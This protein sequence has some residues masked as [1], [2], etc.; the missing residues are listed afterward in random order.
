[1]ALIQA[2]FLSEC[3]MRTVTVQAIVPFDKLAPAGAPQPQRTGFKTLYLLHGV[4]GSENDWVSYTRIQRWAEARGLAVVMPSGENHFYLDCAANGERFGEFIGKELPEKMQCLFHLS[5]H[6]EDNFIAGLS[7]G[8]YGAIVNG[9][10]F[11]DRFGCIAGLSS[12]LVLDGALGRADSAGDEPALTEIL[13]G[14]H[15]STT[16]FGEKASLRDSDRDYYVLAHR[17][18]Q[19]GNA[20]KIYLCCGLQDSLLEANRR[21]A[22]F[23]QSEGLDCTYVESEG[24]HEW[25]FWDRSI[26]AILNWLPLETENDGIGSGNVR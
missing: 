22:G 13:F 24:A 12:A 5:P 21:Y 17:A 1:M 10:R 16:I 7:M 4:L 14:P 19:A 3:L 8:G 20:P 26:E 9:L 15:Y 18:A 2:R 6:R 25:D 23:L 11:A